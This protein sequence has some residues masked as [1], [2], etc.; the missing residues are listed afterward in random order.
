MNYAS[1]PINL[2]AAEWHRDF[3]QWEQTSKAQH[4][5]PVPPVFIVVCRD[6]A[7]AKEVHSWLANGN[8][9][10]GVAPDWF[11]NTPGQEVTVRIDSKVVEDIE[12]G[13]TKDETRRLRFI[14]DT[15]GKAEWPGGKVPEDWLELVRKH[16]DKVA[17]EDNDGSL[18]WIDERIPPGR[19]VRCIVSVAMLAE[20]WDANTVKHIIGLRP[21][22]SQLLC[23]QVVGR[24]LRRKSYALNDETQMFAEETAKVFGVPFELI[25]FKVS[26][27]GWQSRF[28][29]AGQRTTVRRQC[30]CR[31]CFQRSHSQPSAS[32]RKSL[33]AKAAASPA[34][35]CLSASMCRRQSVLFWRRSRRELQRRTP[36]SPSWPKG[37]P[38]VA[39]RSMS[40]SIRRSPSILSP[41]AT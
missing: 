38:G 4:K 19:D 6:T 22:G 11:R 2:L 23:E 21:F 25:P 39:V 7:V 29:R 27:S 10:Y 18:K 34:M 30:R 14:L 5:H 1:A 35:Y 12:E 32:S 37:R 13:G 31:C 33:T 17:S 41:D 40:I 28:A 8:D 26:R 3:V 20:G 36:K 15:V 9:S 16:N 24:A